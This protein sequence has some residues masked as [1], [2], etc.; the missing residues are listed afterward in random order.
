VTRAVVIAGPDGY[1]VQEVE[2]APPRAGEVRVRMAAAGVCHSDL[3]VV[4]R[5][6]TGMFLPAVLGHEGAGVIEELGPDVTGHR[7]GDHVIL[8]VV[9]QCG[10]CRYCC[11]GQPTLCDQGRFGRGGLLRDGTTRVSAGDQDIGQMAGLGTWCGE[12]V[13]AADV[14]IRIDPAMPLPQAAIIGCGVVTGYGGAVAVGRTRPEETVA[15]IGCGGVGLS[16]VQ[17]ARISGAAQI[18]AVD[19]IRGKLD[20]ALKMGATD[21]VDSSEADP[22]SA[23]LDLTGGEGVDVALDFVGA[24]TTSAQA[25]AMTRRGGRCVFTGLSDRSWTVDVAAFLRQGKTLVGNYMGM[26]DFRKAFAE[27]IDLYQG[28]RLLLDEMV[29]RTIALDDVPDAFRAMTAGEVARSVITTW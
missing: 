29:S 5:G 4:E 3:N 23:V 26:M 28:G 12:A 25:I 19:V 27:L 14:A 9:A 1:A 21:V 16:G 22:V 7:A 11:S 10:K 13:V 20:H 24:Q 17:G 8:A 6:G 15:V 18:I 2:V